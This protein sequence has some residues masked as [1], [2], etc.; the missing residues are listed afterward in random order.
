MEI[1][2]SKGKFAAQV[3]FRW[4]YDAMSKA[5]FLCSRASIK[6]D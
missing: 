2:K 4:A 3:A 1:A 5:L 6:K